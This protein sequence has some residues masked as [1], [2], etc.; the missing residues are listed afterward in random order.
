MK[1][2]A[3]ILIYILLSSILLIFTIILSLNINNVP[4]ANKETTTVVMIK[5]LV[6]FCF[7]LSLRLNLSQK[8]GPKKNNKYISLRNKNSFFFPTNFLDQHL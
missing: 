8:K 7:L 1:Y 2:K 3:K 4:S 6:A 5:L